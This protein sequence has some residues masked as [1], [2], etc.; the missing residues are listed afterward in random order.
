MY[1]YLVLCVHFTWTANEHELNSYPNGVVFSSA[2]APPIPFSDDIVKEFLTKNRLATEGELLRAIRRSLGDVLTRRRV[3]RHGSMQRK[4]LYN[5]NFLPG[6][7]NRV[8]CQSLSTSTLCKMPWTVLEKR[9]C[10]L[11]NCSERGWEKIPR[12]WGSTG[13]LLEPKMFS[14]LVPLF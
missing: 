6:V 5:V 13:K 11:H 7:S 14:I 2:G 1:N 9:A 4:E 12:K 8:S 10:L 3:T